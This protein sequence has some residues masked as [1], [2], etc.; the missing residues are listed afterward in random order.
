MN[1]NFK[2]DFIK[3]YLKLEKELSKFLSNHKEITLKNT[4]SIN[5]LWFDTFFAE[6]KVAIYLKENGI[7]CYGF[8]EFQLRCDE[9]CK[10]IKELYAKVK[11]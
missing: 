5:I 3:A 10:R 7:Q 4:N 9:I 11:S 8:D 6:P 2:H 1:N